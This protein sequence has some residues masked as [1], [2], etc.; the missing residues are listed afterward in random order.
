[1]AAHTPTD[2]EVAA[3]IASSAVDLPDHT[4]A[5]ALHRQVDRYADNAA[6]VWMLGDQ[7][8]RL[9]W[10]ELRNRAAAAAIALLQLNPSRERVALVSGLLHE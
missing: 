3:I 4:V 6:L 8:T 2:R 5:E 10:S 9:S 7:V 1:M